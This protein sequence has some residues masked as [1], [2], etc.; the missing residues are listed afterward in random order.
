MF[1]LDIINL[2]TNFPLNVAYKIIFDLLSKDDGL[3][4][5]TK[6]SINN[7]IEAIKFCMENNCMTFN[8]KNYLQISG[9]PMGCNLSPVI[10]EAV[11]SHIFEVAINEFQVKPKLCKFYVDDSFIILSKRLI[12][13]FYEHINEVGKKTGNIKFTIEYET[14]DSLPFLDVLVKRSGHKIE[15]SVYRKPTNSNRYLN[16]YSHHCKQHKIAVI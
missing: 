1:S 10:A 7:I 16:F 6:L 4:D 12:N 2:F 3:K 9:A 14:N 5:R 8:G 13:K 11:V 15:T